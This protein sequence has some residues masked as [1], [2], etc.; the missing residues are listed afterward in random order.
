MTSFRLNRC[1]FR[2]QLLMWNVV[3]TL[4]TIIFENIDKSTF[5]EIFCAICLFF[6]EYFFRNQDEINKKTILIFFLLS[7]YRLLDSMKVPG[8][9]SSFHICDILD[10]NNPSDTKTNNNNNNNN[11]NSTSNNNNHSTSGEFQTF[12]CNI[13]AILVNI[14]AVSGNKS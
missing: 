4:T 13:L 8:Q 2:F 7:I 11:N 14:L 5:F 3:S 1:I 10:L 6:W 12:F 9:R